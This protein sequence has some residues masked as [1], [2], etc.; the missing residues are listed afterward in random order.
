MQAKKPLFLLGGYGGASLAIC[1]ALQGQQ[2]E[3]LTK[4]YQCR[5]ESYKTLLQE[6]NQ[7]I[8][9]QQLDQAPIDYQALVKSFAEIGIN[10]LNNGL[11]DQ[12]NRVLF[13][14]INAEEAIGL[15]LTGLA[16]IKL[17]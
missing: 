11:T 13:T 12:E 14:T 4:S 6:F 7:R 17:T 2:P 3:T 15:I 1:Q 10:G 5:N 9:E 16:R 8:A